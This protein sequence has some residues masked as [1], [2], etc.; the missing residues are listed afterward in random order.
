VLAVAQSM[1]PLARPGSHTVVQVSGSSPGGTAEFSPELCSSLL[2]SKLLARC[3]NLL[4]PAVLSDAK[5]RD[6][7]LAEPSLVAQ[8]QLIRKSSRVLFGIGGLGPGSTVRAAE[9]ANNKTIDAYIAKGAVA[10]LIGRF[11]DAKGKPVTGELDRRMIGIDLDE[12]KQLPERLCVAG[13]PEKI[14][15]IRAALLGGYVNR[16]VTDVPSGRALLE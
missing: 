2:A 9:L 14:A 6:R 8:F 15:A 7:L 1:P 4:A 13:G 10:V 12:L 11:I 5:L 3:A 16:L